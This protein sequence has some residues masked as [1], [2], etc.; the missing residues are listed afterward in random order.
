MKPARISWLQALVHVGSLV[1]LLVTVYLYQTGGLGVNP[2]QAAEQRT[3]FTALVLLILS[4]ACT[5]LNT[6]FRLPI[7]LKL[8]RPLGLYGYLYAFIHLTI[9]LWLDYGFELRFILLDLAEKRY[10]LVGLAAFLL[11]TFLAVTSFDWWKKRL[12]KG[13]KRLHRLVYLINLLV[14]LHFGWAIKGDFF[15]LQGDVVRP[16]L[17]GLIVILLLAA[18][19]PAVRKRIAGQGKLLWQ[20]L[21]EPSARRQPTSDLPPSPPPA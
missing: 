14:V 17:A 4:L 10:I 7:L 16:M 12:K 18:R 3:G 9:F 1:P 19:I 11:L 13:W 8:R 15:R 6:L 20:R 5:P 21:T 2:I